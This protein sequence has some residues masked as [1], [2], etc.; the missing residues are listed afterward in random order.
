MWLFADCVPAAVCTFVQ[1]AGVHRGGS[2]EASGEGLSAERAFQR[3]RT[4]LASRLSFYGHSGSRGAAAQGGRG[5]EPPLLGRAA[6]GPS[7]ANAGGRKNSRRGLFSKR[8]LFIDGRVLR[9]DDLII[10]PFFVW[11]KYG[12]LCLS[13]KQ[14]N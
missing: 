1:V 9:K 6:E 7:E 10:D 14:S 3:A 8:V 4:S 12:I 5:G 11:N 2:V 13:F